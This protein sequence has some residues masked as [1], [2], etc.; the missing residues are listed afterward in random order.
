MLTLRGITWDHPRGIDPLID[1]SRAYALSHNI[2]VEWTARSLEE[3]ET[4]PLNE[5]ARQCDLMVIDHPHVG[6]AA[7]EGSLVPFDESVVATIGPLE[8]VRP[9]RDGF[10]WPARPFGPLAGQRDHQGSD[11]LQGA[12]PGREMTAMHMRAVRPSIAR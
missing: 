11:P 8:E 2:Q 9:D 12:C 5:L 7:R 4:T 6:D 10:P 3:F 1:C